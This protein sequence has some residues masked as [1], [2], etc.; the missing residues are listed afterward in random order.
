MAALLALLGPAV[1]SH[2]QPLRQRLKHVAHGS[3]FFFFISRS[4]SE[5]FDRDGRGYGLSDDA[6]SFALFA[7]E[8]AN[9]T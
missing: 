9:K 4:D 1:P 5:R 6:F 2:A 3:V 8:Q 7:K